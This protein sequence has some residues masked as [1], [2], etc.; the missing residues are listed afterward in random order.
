MNQLRVRELIK[1]LTLDQRK[2]LKKLLPKSSLPP[3]EI[4]TNPYP[5]ALLS[6]FPK[7]ECYSLLGCV[8]EELLRIRPIN[9]EALFT[10][11]KVW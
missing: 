11:T 6:I 8:A 7:D 4:S 5:A 9:L 3:P 1:G 2:D 10:A